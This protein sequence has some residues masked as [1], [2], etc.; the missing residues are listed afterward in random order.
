VSLNLLDQGF[1]DDRALTDLVLKS[2]SRRPLIGNALRQHH[3]DHL[4]TQRPQRR[5]S[6]RGYFPTKRSRLL[7]RY[8]FFLYARTVRRLVRDNRH[9]PRLLPRML[10]SAAARAALGTSRRSQCLRSDHG[11]LELLKS[12]KRFASGS[13]LRRPITCPHCVPSVRSFPQ[14]PHLD[15]W[16]PIGSV[17]VL[18]MGT[19]FSFFVG[20]MRLLG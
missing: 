8:G 18:A 5:A 2:R 3:S 10:F 20:V 17:F 9:L 19:L 12:L 11:P 6:C 14:I 7:L 13:L 16:R 15:G 1:T 4:P